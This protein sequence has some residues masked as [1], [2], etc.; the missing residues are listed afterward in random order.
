VSWRLEEALNGAAQMSS[1]INIRLVAARLHP[2]TGLAPTLAAAAS[3]AA[4]V[5]PGTS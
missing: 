5:R 4:N 3:R 1:S 2:G